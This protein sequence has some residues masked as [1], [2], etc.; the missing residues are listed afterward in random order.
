MIVV[1]STIHNKDRGSIYYYS[2]LWFSIMDNKKRWFSSVLRLH[3]N[4]NITE[5]CWK[6]K[7][8]SLDSPTGIVMFQLLLWT[9]TRKFFSLNLAQSGLAV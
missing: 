9:H 7:I 1:L 8:P 6:T 3:L 2:I 5:N 4:C